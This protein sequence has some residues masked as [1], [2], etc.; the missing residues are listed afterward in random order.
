MYVQNVVQ[1]EQK[2]VTK[3]ART[4]FSVCR[5]Q[6]LQRK[7]FFIVLLEQVQLVG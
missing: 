1:V 3:M 4:C 6:L 7:L 5:L 2:S